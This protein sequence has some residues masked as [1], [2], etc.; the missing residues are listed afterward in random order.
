MARFLRYKPTD[1]RVMLI[2]ISAVAG[3]EFEQTKTT[4]EVFGVVNNKTRQLIKVD[5]DNEEAVDLPTDVV[6]RTGK[7]YAEFL[8]YDNV[9][10]TWT[11]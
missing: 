3:L 6:D 8:R 4:F 1:N 7:G 11:N 5:V 10:L 9:V 2:N